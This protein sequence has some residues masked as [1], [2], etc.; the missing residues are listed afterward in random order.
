[1]M[2][3]DNMKEVCQEVL[4]KK[5]SVG[6]ASTS[7]TCEDQRRKDQENHWRREDAAA[8]ARLDKQK[9]DEIERL[10]RENQDLLR[11]ASGK[12]SRELDTIKADNQALVH[13]IVTLRDEVENLKRG[14]KRGAEALT[15]KSP[16]I[17]P[18]RGRSR[19]E[20]S[21]QTPVEWAKLTEAYRRLRDEKDMAEREVSA[22]KERIN[23]IRILVPS[24]SKKR[25]IVRRTSGKGGASPEQKAGDQVKVTFVRRIGEERD[26][27]F[28]RV[29]NDLGKLRKAQLETL[30]IDEEIDY[31]GVKK[32]AGDLAQIYTIRAFDRPT[33]RK[34][35]SDQEED[36]ERSEPD[37]DESSADVAGTSTDDHLVSESS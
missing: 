29:I 2:V 22:L 11:V 25:P 8:R 17:E 13:D 32:T 27:F 33:N 19:Q 31:G 36:E 14:N 18:A 10:R 20:E 26:V 28:K 16:P 1:M 24:S 30:C 15:E 3:K 21:C 6:Q 37:Q 4:G 35:M 34:L 9:A 5:T 7:G 12:A 23:R